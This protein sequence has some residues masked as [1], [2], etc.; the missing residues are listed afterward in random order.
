MTSSELILGGFQPFGTTVCRHS[1]WPIMQQKL[2]PA[3]MQQL[4][5]ASEVFAHIRI[6]TMNHRQIDMNYK[7]YTVAIKYPKHFKTTRDA[8]GVIQ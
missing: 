6:Y 3:A 1:N 8:I 7:V 4:L 5:G 2:T